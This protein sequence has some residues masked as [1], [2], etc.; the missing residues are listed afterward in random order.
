M[1]K[2]N[3]VSCLIVQFQ[4]TFVVA[5]LNCTMLNCISTGKSFVGEEKG[6]KHN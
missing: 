4:C 2:R 5:I 6:D 3:V 1:N